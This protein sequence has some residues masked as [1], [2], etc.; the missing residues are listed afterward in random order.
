[1]K[2]LTPSNPIKR[3]RGR[4]RKRPKKLRA[5]KAYDSREARHELRKK[6]SR[7]GSPVE[8]SKAVSGCDDTAG[9]LSAPARGFTAFV[10]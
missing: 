5:D 4:P 7:R 2:Y 6:G 9:W 1:M 10:A 3:P 8:A